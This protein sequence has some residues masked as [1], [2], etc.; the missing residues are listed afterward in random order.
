MPPRLR[1]KNKRRPFK[2]KQRK[3]RETSCR[4]RRIID[5]K[6][7]RTISTEGRKH[8][9]SWKRKEKA[10]QRVQKW[11]LELFRNE[12]NQSWRWSWRSI[13]D[14]SSYSK[15]RKHNEITKEAKGLERWFSWNHSLECVDVNQI[16]QRIK[17]N[18]R[19]F[20]F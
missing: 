10:G 3:K 1:Q 11:L 7:W 13:S 2:R 20:P 9:S 4:K 19:K 15:L 14:F 6:Q 5:N 12:T 18:R 16:W 17:S 8:K